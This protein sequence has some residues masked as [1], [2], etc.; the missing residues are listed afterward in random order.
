MLRI[1]TMAL[2]AG[3][4][5]SI[6]TGCASQ[7][8]FVPTAPGGS[9]APAAKR[10][11]FIYV[12]D[13][14]KQEL[15]VYPAHQSNPK[16]IRILG[17]AQGIVN[18]GGVATDR[19]GNVYIAN[20]SGGNVLEFSVGGISFLKAYTGQ[21]NHPV[22][23]AV[24]D[25][26]TVYV[27][28]QDARYPGGAT[29]AIVEFPHGKTYPGAII[30]DP[31]NTQRPLRGIAVTDD[32]QVFVSTS[33]GQDV[34]P[35]PKSSCYQPPDNVIYDFI[36]PTLV[37]PITLV[38]NTQV[39]GLAMDSN[40]DL[41]ASDYCNGSLQVYAGSAWDHAGTVPYKYDVPI[42]QTISRDHLIIVPCGGGRN[43]GYVAVRDP[44]TGKQ[45][46][47]WSGLVSPIG[48]AAGP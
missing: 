2:I 9:Q 45:D 19:S 12:A 28:N 38:A 14:A 23:V 39:W 18:V 24:D 46:E 33:Q 47:I 34:W 22:N 37:R 16:P 43:P 26:G 40:G 13:R 6:L 11:K 48:A 30:N 1:T 3:L 5:A 32:G 25:G 35:P 44:A 7:Q 4:G 8:S 31:T 10:S 20:G 29:S 21:L 42:Y 15:L 27:V 36:F 41:Y 17:A